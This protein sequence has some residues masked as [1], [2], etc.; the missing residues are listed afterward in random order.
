MDE[1]LGLDRR[2]STTSGDTTELVGLQ[3][4]R[5]KP[6][7]ITIIDRNDRRLK[8]DLEM[9]LAKQTNLDRGNGFAGER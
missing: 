6:W 5:Y 7:L 1:S 8:S 2:S 4:G 3:L 9:A